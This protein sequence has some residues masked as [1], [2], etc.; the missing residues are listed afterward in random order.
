[1]TL[2]TPLKTMVRYGFS[3]IGLDIRRIE[4]FPKTESVRMQTLASDIPHSRIQPSA[5][6][7]PW[8]VDEPF[9][10]T[11]EI[12]RP[13]TLV[14]LY[15]CYEL[16]TLAARLD[17]LP[18][19]VI[20]VGVW[21]GGTGALIAKQVQNIAPN[22]TVYL[23]DTFKGVVGAGSR[24]TRYKGGEHADTSLE[25]VKELIASIGLTNTRLVVGVFPKETAVQISAERLAL[26]HVNVDVYDSAKWCFEWAWPRTVL[27]GAIVFDDYGFHGC[28]GVT[29]MVNEIDER[30]AVKLYNLNGHAIVIKCAD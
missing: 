22:R 14:D 28:E 17:R 21:R 23:C 13:Y 12:I 8:Q 9:N 2:L 10:L 4:P 29:R 15:R 26:V 16:W 27:G 20:E 1:M 25:I 19:D 11:F 18:G 24:D 30:N 7:S 3:S 5:T 6:Y